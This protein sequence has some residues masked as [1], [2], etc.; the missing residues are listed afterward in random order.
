MR[1]VLKLSNYEYPTHAECSVTD[2]EIPIQTAQSL[3]T[4]NVKY[5]TE[6][7]KCCLK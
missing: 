1:I 3:V 6:K 5:K 2:T 4:G 7:K